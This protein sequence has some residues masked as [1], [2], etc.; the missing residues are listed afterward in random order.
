MEQNE[1]ITALH[2]QLKEAAQRIFAGLDIRPGKY[3]AAEADKALNISGRMDEIADA[4]NESRQMPATAET[5]AAKIARIISDLEAVGIADEEITISYD[6]FNA[7]MPA[8]LVL[9]K[10]AEWEKEFK[11]KT[12][13]KAV[14]IKEEEG[15]VI[16]SCVVEFPKEA[17][18][19]AEFAGTDSMRPVCMGV[20][21]DIKNSCIVATDTHAVT[22]YPV[23]ISDVEGEPLNL[24]IDPKIIKAVA[25]QRCEAKL[26]KDA[27]K[28]ISIRTEKGEVYTCGNIKGRYVDYR[29]VYPKVNRAGLVELTKDGA[30]ALVNFAKSTVKQTKDTRYG[31]TCIKIEIPAYSA[32]GTATYYDTYYQSEKSVKFTVK[33]SPRIDIVFGIH[34]FHL[35][36]VTKNWNGCFWFLDPSRPITFDN[37]KSACTIVMP[38]QLLVE[39]AFKC[40]SCAGVVDALKRHNYDI[41]EAEATSYQRAEEKR[42]SEESAT[43]TR[44]EKEECA[45]RY[46]KVKGT[47]ADI[48]TDN[49]EIWAVSPNGCRVKY[50]GRFRRSGEMVLFEKERELLSAPEPPEDDPQPPAGPPHDTR[51]EE[52]HNMPPKPKEA[53][54]NAPAAPPGIPKNTHIISGPPGQ[55]LIITP[56]INKNLILQNHDRNNRMAPPHLHNR[57]LCLPRLPGG[58]G[59]DLRHLRT[60][61]SCIVAPCRNHRQVGKEESRGSPRR[62]GE[63]D[64]RMGKEMGKAPPFTQM[65]ISHKPP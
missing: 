59:Y 21:L 15:E 55:L 13:D 8:G 3:T 20:Y 31:R 7:S 45:L 61:N 47:A 22:E 9:A 43:I 52:R 46:C 64:R 50:I 18:Y 30:K 65:I 23:I 4:R 24:N 28:N 35:A 37:I 40:G 1:I 36:M 53:A 42:I 56:T 62:A 6:T 54:R 14:F 16:G 34:A 11:I 44:A 26:I 58:S 25:G 41:A 29:R 27:E 10:L 60:R 32:I 48:V 2:A 12:I 49:D 5:N 51:K 38:M 33:G 39:T 57:G 63:G 19:V 17:K